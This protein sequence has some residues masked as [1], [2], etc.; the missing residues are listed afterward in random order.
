MLRAFKRCFGISSDEQSRADNVVLCPRC[1]FVASGHVSV[2]D[3]ARMHIEFNEQFAEKCSNNFTVTRPKT[4]LNYT[5]CPVL[6]YP[7]F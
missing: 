2:E 1:Y 5:N 4:W 3:Y 7:L 6:Y